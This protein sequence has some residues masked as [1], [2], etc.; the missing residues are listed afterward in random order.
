MPDVSVTNS[1]EAIY[2]RFMREGWGD[3]L[4]I[5]PPTAERVYDMLRYTDREPE[6]VIGV[7]PPGRG[8][9]SVLL[10]AVNAV[11]AG[12]H[13]GY[14]PVVIAAV[15][16]M[17]EENFN[18]YALQATTNPVALAGFV[19]GP[20][21]EALGFNTGC[22]CLGQGNRANPGKRHCWPRHTFSCCEHWRRAAREA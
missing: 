12:C 21:I 4:P 9:A 16:A 3:G 15:K 5:I 2:D 18:L 6:E 10:I 13:P 19:N 1:P 14:L 20:V 7:I 22:N 8:E 17:C 11:M